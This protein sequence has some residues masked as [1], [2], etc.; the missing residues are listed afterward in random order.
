MVEAGQAGTLAQDS[1]L[2]NQ[3]GAAMATAV[4]EHSDRA[5]PIPI[6]NQKQR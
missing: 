2:C 3:P 5:V 1:I 6:P 4:Q